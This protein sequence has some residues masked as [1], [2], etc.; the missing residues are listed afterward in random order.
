MTS[1]AL[2]KKNFGL[3][4]FD[5]SYDKIKKQLVI[6]IPVKYSKY[7]NKFK[8]KVKT[9]NMSKPDRVLVQMK[10]LTFDLL[11]LEADSVLPR[12]HGHWISQKPRPDSLAGVEASPS[13][14]S[15][16]GFG[17]PEPDAVA[18]LS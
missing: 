17:D 1:P 11:D 6:F 13:A 10:M 16:S 14:F 5:D 2:F 12:H 3:Q 18:P 4:S 8:W 7:K 9:P 15:P